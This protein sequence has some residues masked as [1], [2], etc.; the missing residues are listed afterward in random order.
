MLWSNKKAE[1]IIENYLKYFASYRDNNICLRHLFPG[2]FILSFNWIFG[3][4]C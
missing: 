4:N 1:L 3:A 2:V